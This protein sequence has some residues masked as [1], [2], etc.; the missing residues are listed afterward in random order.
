MQLNTKRLIRIRKDRNI[1][2]QEIADIAGVSKST[3]HRIESGLIKEP[4]FTLMLKIAGILEVNFTAF[5][6]L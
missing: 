2:Q 3:I 6:E 4:K 1:S 5:V